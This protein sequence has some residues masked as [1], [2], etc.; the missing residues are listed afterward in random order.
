MSG[1]RASTHVQCPGQAWCGRQNKQ[2]IPLLW[3]MGMGGILGT[4]EELWACPSNEQSICCGLPDLCPFCSL[5]MSPP[6]GS[7]GR[8][9]GC[10]PRVWA[11]QG[12]AGLAKLPVE[13]C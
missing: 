2:S 12:L 10:L 1:S 13:K 3:H 6:E 7:Q 9:M 5:W 11:Y 4:A 8:E